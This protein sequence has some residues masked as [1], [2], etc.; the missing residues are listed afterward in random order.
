MAVDNARL[1]RESQQALTEREKAV[2][3]RDEVL[4][5]VSHDLRG[6][7]NNIGLGAS[8]L[9]ETCDL[10]DARRQL[11]LI[12]RSAVR[13]E[14]MIDEL[15][16]MATIQAKG[17]MLE[18]TRQEIGSL[19]MAAVEA[20]QAKAASNGI[21][22]VRECEPTNVTVS[23][24][25]DRVERVFGNMIGNAIKFCRPGDLIYV[26]CRVVDD[27]VVFSISD[28]GPGIPPEQVPHLFE[29]YWSAGRQAIKK[30]TG[31]GLY[32]CKGIVEA[33]GGKLWV[34]S[35]VSEGTEFFFTLPMDRG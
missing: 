18:R 4:A 16:D 15:L 33:H 8:M 24:D 7:L 3:S 23:C 2:Q 22:L 27:V 17:L 10:P 11:E 26:R 29:P 25:R 9:H 31:L 1:Y 6:P 5:I 14:H 30:G 19:V 35:T 12:Q 28:T 34:E 13:M 21:R 20:H 32:I